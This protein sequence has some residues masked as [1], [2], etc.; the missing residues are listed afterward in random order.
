VIALMQHRKVRLVSLLLLG[1]AC[2]AVQGGIQDRFG[3]G[4]AAADLPVAADGACPPAPEL[5]PDC[6]FR[7]KRRLVKKAAPRQIIMQQTAV[8]EDVGLKRPQPKQELSF[9]NKVKVTLWEQGRLGSHFVLYETASGPRCGW[10]ENAAILPEGRN[11]PMKISD[12]GE[13]GIAEF[14]L[15]GKGSGLDAKLLVQNDYKKDDPGRGKGARV[16]Y[17]FTDPTPYQTIKI[18]NVLSVYDYARYKGDVWYFVGGTH[19]TRAKGSEQ[20]L[21]GWLKSSDVI[22]WSTLVNVYYGDGKHALEIYETDAEAESATNAFAHQGDDSP[23]DGKKDKIIPRFPMLDTIKTESVVLHEIAFP[24]EACDSQGHCISASAMAGARDKLGSEVF[25]ASNVD[26]LFVIDAT[27]SMVKYFPYVVRGIKEFLDEVNA[28]DRASARF[29]IVVYGDFLNK[30]SDREG[31]QFARVVPFGSADNRRQME[32]L[33]TAKYFDD[34]MADLPEAAF[35]ALVKAIKR[36]DWR[37]EAGWRLTIWIG[38]HPNRGGSLTGHRKQVYTEKDVIAA[39]DPERGVWAAVNVAGSYQPEYNNLFM[40]QAQRIY[41]GFD[42]GFGIKP[43][44]AYDMRSIK[45]TPGGIV[46]AVKEKL[47][48]IKYQ[49]NKVPEAMALKALGLSAKE[50]DRRLPGAVLA[51]RYVE[52]RLSMSDAELKEFFERSQL[53]RRGF[54]RQSKGGVDPDWRYWV[55]F[56]PSDMEDIVN[57]SENLCETLSEDAPELNTVRETM[58]SVLKGVTGD[59]PEDSDDPDETLRLFLAKRLQVPVEQFSDLLDKNID[60]FV[61][62]Y[63]GAPHSETEKFKVLMCKK[64]ALLRLAFNGKRVANDLSDLEFIS[65][66][67]AWG[68]R[69]GTARSFNWLWKSEHGVGFYYIPLDYIL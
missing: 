48:N 56:K 45:E 23:A 37:K 22:P 10:I 26:F 3:G 36:A 8:Y 63:I 32:K 43:Q 5:P 40:T 21:Y 61:K 68:P 38:D 46:K 51:R 6:D 18:F 65:S 17:N 1:L 27:K 30:T 66:S 69:A 41:E 62:W 24:G 20:I 29:S 59:S 60:G 50:I 55:S 7:C 9:G 44:R 64:S 11:G 13:E 15:R 47:H 2:T 49:G 58:V 16:Y 14:K 35:A 28:E 25:T 33:M 57:A 54:V 52:E 12:L 67:N 31:F 53:V 19:D 39:L 42:K 4:L 34:N